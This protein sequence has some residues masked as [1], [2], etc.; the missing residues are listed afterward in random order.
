[1]PQQLVSTQGISATVNHIEGQVERWVKEMGQSG[2][3]PAALLNQLQQKGQLPRD[4]L[5]LVQ[6]DI[7]GT[8]FDRT[9]G[10]ILLNF[11]WMFGSHSPSLLF[12][13][14]VRFPIQMFVSRR[15]LAPGRLDR[16]LAP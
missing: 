5:P 4:L 3:L 11:V 15:Q 14:Q 8:E 2:R 1:M 6:G 12:V 10:S 9:S 13:F 16:E 7:A